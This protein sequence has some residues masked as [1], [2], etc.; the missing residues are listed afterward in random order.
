M[1][2]K[3]I[4]LSG[5]MGCGKTTVMGEASD[6]LATQHIAHA[7]ID[8]DAI[9]T[10]SIARETDADLRQRNLAAFY[11]NF[12]SAGV[13][14]LILALALEARGELDDLRQAMPGATIVVCRLTASVATMEGR[15]RVREPGMHQATF[16]ARARE[17]QH[18]L[19]AAQLEDF[20]V[21]N[22]DRN[23]TEVARDVLERAGWL[24]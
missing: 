13:S 18:V 7:Y 15:L 21:L 9:G 2:I 22:D 6:L 14:H 1:P 19:D 17:L 4:V 24:A 12:A 8:L 20:T 23:V 10:V 5:S 3:V 16:V 11:A